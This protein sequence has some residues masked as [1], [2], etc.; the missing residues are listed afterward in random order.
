MQCLV[1]KKEGWEAEEGDEGFEIEGNFFL[2]GVVDGTPYETSR[3]T[4][5]RHGIDSIS[6]DSIL[7]VV[8][9][10]FKDRYPE[11]N[12]LTETSKTD[13]DAGGWCGLPFHPTCFE[14]FKRVSLL[15]LGSIDVQGL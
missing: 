2:T 14:I 9:P 10:A 5:T 13:K 6:Y 1:G 3:M 8:S 12:S 7:Q 4:P 15:R 11:Q